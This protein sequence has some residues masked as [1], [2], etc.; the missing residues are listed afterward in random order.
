M[1]VRVSVLYL[2]SANLKLV[3]VRLVTMEMA[4]LVVPKVDNVSDIQSQWEQSY[5]IDI[6][7]LSPC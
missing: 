1:V 6:S 7:P 3:S 5:Q 2:P 4:L